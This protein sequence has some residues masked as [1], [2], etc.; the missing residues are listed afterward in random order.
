MFCS[1]T[2]SLSTAQ[3]LQCFSKS[4]ISHV[5]GP[6]NDRRVSFGRWF[7]NQSRLLNWC[8]ATSIPIFVGTCTL[9]FFDFLFSFLR[10]F[11]QY[12]SCL[13]Y[14][15]FS[16][17]DKFVPVCEARS[18]KKWTDSSADSVHILS[19]EIS[20]PVVPARTAVQY[21]TDTVSLTSCHVIVLPARGR[22]LEY[23]R[24]RFRLS[25]SFNVILNIFLSSI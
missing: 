22:C 19:T 4:E 10:H 25:P 23:G 14:L 24:P 11:G 18:V 21:F 6:V 7:R 12:R 2:A 8:R 20:V 16:G 5:K 13:P 15:K 17:N 1:L 3:E 9:A